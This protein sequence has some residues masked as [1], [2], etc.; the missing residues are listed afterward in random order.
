M[1]TLLKEMDFSDRY[2]GT[3][4]RDKFDNTI[5]DLQ[6]EG[7]I[8][9]WRYVDG[10][11]EDRIRKINWIKSYWSKLNVHIRPAEYVVKENKKIISSPATS[12]Q[13]LE[14]EKH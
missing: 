1:S 12:V 4:I 10:I 9:Q 13:K 3:V 5:D 6:A 7:V 2:N 11:D 14:F 8:K